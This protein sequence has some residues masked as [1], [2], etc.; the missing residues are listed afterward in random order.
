MILGIY[1][2]VFDQLDIEKSV[3]GVLTLCDFWDLEKFALAKIRIRREPKG[4]FLA[5]AIFGCF[6]SLMRYRTNEIKQH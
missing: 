2:M 4:E 5:N 3:Q 6:I 1:A